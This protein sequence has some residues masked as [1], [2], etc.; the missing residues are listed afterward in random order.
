MER[1]YRVIRL[2]AS[3]SIPQLLA[4]MALFKAGTHTQ[5]LFPPLVIVMFILLSFSC[6]TSVDIR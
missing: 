5:L 3:P 6:F 2:P 4:V 1:Q